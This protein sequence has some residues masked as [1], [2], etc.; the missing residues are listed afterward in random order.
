LHAKRGVGVRCDLT[1]QNG[2]K[3]KVS[4]ACEPKSKVCITAIFF[5]GKDSKQV[6]L[7]LVED[8]QGKPMTREVCTFNKNNEVRVCVDWDDGSKR[9]DAKNYKGDW[10]KI[11][12]E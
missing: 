7:K 12:D 8:L 10:Y 3:P 11:A 5:D 4:R 1:E 6:M 2:G 9:R